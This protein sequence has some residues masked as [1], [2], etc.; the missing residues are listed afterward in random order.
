MDVLVTGGRRDYRKKRSGDFWRKKGRRPTC[1]GCEFGKNFR[2]T[3]MGTSLCRTGSHCGNCLEMAFESSPGI[4]G[5]IV[6]CGMR[7]LECGKVRECFSPPSLPR[8]RGFA[9]AAEFAASGP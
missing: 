2:K 3:G 1:F 8:Y 9:R 6:D 4:W 5:V 7:I